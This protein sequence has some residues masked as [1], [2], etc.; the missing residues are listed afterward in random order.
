[1]RTLWIG[2]TIAAVCLIPLTAALI[3]RKR[4]RS[5]WPVGMG[6][7]GFFA[8]A[9]I[10]ETVFQL[11]CF[12]SLGPVSRALNASPYRLILFSC[13]CAG[14]FEE[15]GRF[16]IFRNGLQRCSGRAVA[17]GYAI[18]HFGTEILINTVYPLMSR[19]GEIFGPLQAG[20]CLYE[21]LV[22]CAG[23]TALSVLVWYGFCK[24]KKDMLILA[25]C[26]HAVC[27]APLGLL[28]Y[29]LLGQMP[30]EMLFGLLVAGLCSIAL[31]YW[32]KMPAGAMI[33]V[34]EDDKRE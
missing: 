4:F 34:S 3:W 9:A 18:G 20:I 17:A 15:W 7:L 10:V 1:M 14:I 2:L 16:W 30:A 6:A 28:R 25:V 29:G 33:R 31:W 23:H 24:K 8:F 27:D 22:A 5:M 26:I 19:A 21:R 11:V 12:T 13:L 32:R